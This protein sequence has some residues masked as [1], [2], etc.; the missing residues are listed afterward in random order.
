MKSAIIRLVFSILCCLFQSGF[1]ITNI[2]IN[3]PRGLFISII[4][5]LCWITCVIFNILTIREKVKL[6]KEVKGD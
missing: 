2:K 5:Q 1:V 6:R 3:N 4:G